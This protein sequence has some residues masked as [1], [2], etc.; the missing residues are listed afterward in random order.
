VKSELDG[1]FQGNGPEA[2]DGGVQ[3]PVSRAS[4]PS[5]SHGHAQSSSDRAPAPAP[6]GEDGIVRKKHSVRARLFVGN[7][8]KDTGQDV[9]KELFQQFGE[10]IEL[11]VQKEKNFGFVRLVSVSKYVVTK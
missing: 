6:Q 7:L 4:G 2:T 1:S 3:A 10:V 5:P 9:V 8:P 11:F